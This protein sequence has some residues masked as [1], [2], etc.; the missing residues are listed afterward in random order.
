MA[1][2]KRNPILMGNGNVHV[3]VHVQGW[4]EDPVLLHVHVNVPLPATV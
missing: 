2:G 1:K 3:Q 4:R